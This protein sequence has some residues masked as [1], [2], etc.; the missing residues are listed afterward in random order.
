[1][2]DVIQKG[3]TEVP[4]AT[5]FHGNYSSPAVPGMTTFGNEVSKEVLVGNEG[6]RLGS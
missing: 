2:E 4:D 5:V 1:M 3:P 6:I